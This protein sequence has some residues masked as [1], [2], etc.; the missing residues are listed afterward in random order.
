VL[1]AAIGN[2]AE[3]SRDWGGKLARATPEKPEIGARSRLKAGPLTQTK[4][5]VGRLVR[6]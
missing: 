6:D 5:H 1:L 3:H 4:A 2:G